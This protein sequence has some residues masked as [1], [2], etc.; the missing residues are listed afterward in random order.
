MLLKWVKS[1]VVN[2]AK[3][4]RETEDSILIICSGTCADCFTIARFTVTWLCWS[5]SED[6]SSKVW[7]V[8]TVSVKI[9]NLMQD[10]KLLGATDTTKFLWILFSFPLLPNISFYQG[11]FIVR[12][13]SQRLRRSAR[14]Y[15]NW[16]ERKHCSLGFATFVTHSTM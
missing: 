8:Y 10:A 2:L 14:I 13:K 4:K 3:C 7:Q 11:I 16:K 5:W 9:K 15:P 6:G 12:V 1:F